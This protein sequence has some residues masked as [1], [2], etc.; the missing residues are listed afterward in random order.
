MA[1][2]SPGQMFVL[3]YLFAQALIIIAFGIGL[4]PRQ[5]KVFGPALAPLLVGLTLGLGTLASGIAKPGYTE[6]DCVSAA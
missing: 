4:D 6:V 2:V 5:A 3:E 1:L